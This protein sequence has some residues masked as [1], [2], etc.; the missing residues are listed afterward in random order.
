MSCGQNNIYKYRDPN[1]KITF[2]P[3]EDQLKNLEKRREY[4]RKIAVKEDIEKLFRGL[5]CTHN[6][7]PNKENY[8]V[9]YDGQFKYI[10]KYRTE[11]YTHYDGNN[12]ALV[13]GGP[14][15]LSGRLLYGK[16]IDDEYKKC[17]DYDY[18]YSKRRVANWVNP[19]NIVRGSVN[20]TQTNEKVETNKEGWDL[21]N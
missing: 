17:M 1:D 10:Q 6:D 3:R 13:Q 4:Y 12:P 18:I 15:M 19:D 11:L 5:Y 9:G 2:V 14:V 7:I 21:N 20:T 16:K 8:I